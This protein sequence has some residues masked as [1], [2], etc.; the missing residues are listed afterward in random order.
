MIIAIEVLE[1]VANESTA[2]LAEANA[3]SKE[4]LALSRAQ[5]TGVDVDVLGAQHAS[6]KRKRELPL[7]G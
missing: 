2:L 3:L 5:I 7:F 6:L 4:Q 1:D